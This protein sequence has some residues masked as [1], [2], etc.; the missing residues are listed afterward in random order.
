VDKQ[1]G[2]NSHSKPAA[3]EPVQN[4]EI[5]PQD[6]GLF[7]VT[8]WQSIMYSLEVRAENPDAAQDIAMQSDMEE[9]NTHWE[10]D[11]KLIMPPP[12]QIY[13]LGCSAFNSNSIKFCPE[14]GSPASMSISHGE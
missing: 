6:F 14:C 13:C 2:G 11:V 3:A 9:I 5:L 1:L 8:G 12:G 10:Y 4:E 7:L